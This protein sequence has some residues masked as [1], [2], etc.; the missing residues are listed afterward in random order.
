MAGE[1]FGLRADL[2]AELARLGQTLK[3]DAAMHVLPPPTGDRHD[4]V[5]LERV[6]EGAVPEYCIHGYVN[7]VHCRRLCWLGSETVKLVRKRGM[8]PL[9]LDCAN[10]LVPKDQRVAA[11]IVDHRRPDGP[12]TD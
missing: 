3:P 11:H 7:C 12:H 5:L 2:K 6:V 4:V 9:C 8:Y 1:T 10:E